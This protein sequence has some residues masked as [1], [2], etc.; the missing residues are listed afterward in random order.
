M[1]G[2]S[3]LI[4]KAISEFC[5]A[6]LRDSES[7]YLG[8]RECGFCTLRSQL[9]MRLHDADSTT[10]MAKQVRPIWSTCV[11]LIDPKP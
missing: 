4:H 11:F 8:L 9:T 7:L 1:I 2:N 3:T 5:A 6:R 10:D